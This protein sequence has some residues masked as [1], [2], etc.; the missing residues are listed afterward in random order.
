MLEALQHP[1][2][3][4]LGDKPMIFVVTPE[5]RELYQAE[6]AAMH[7]HRKIVFVDRI[8]WR[9]PVVGDTEID[10]YD[11]KE[12]IYLIA[13]DRPDGEV[14]ASARLL[15]TVVP[16]LMSDMFA[17]AC[18]ES[19]PRGPT[20]WEASRF[21]PAP[22]ICGRSTRTALL[23]ETICGVMETA[24]LF[25]VEQ[26]TFVAN[27]ALLPLALNCGWDAR[28]LGPTLRDGDDEATAAAA[29]ITSEGLRR[30]RE[31]NAVLAPVTRFHAAPRRRQ[32][33][34]PAMHGRSRLL[35]TDRSA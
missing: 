32:A 28:T 30:V 3:K 15:S 10:R 8:G 18:H 11:R 9:I 35:E 2:C 34:T 27:S 6:L 33:E 23:M 29:M 17:A 7:R 21:C 24:L 25:G 14:L 4:D 20:I 26:V 16:H 13:K 19:V 1:L 31:R 22:N 12:T 5:N